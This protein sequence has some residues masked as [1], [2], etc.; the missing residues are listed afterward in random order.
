MQ[1][2]GSPGQSLKQSCYLALALKD[3]IRADRDEGAV[4]VLGRGESAQRCGGSNRPRGTYVRGGD[5]FC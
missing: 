4:S 2:R 3:A 5:A 1:G